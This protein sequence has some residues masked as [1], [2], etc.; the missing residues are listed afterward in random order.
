[1]FDIDRQPLVTT[2]RCHECPASMTI[3]TDSRSQV[4][5]AIADYELRHRCRQTASAA[6]GERRGST[7]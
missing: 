3:E 2:I 6:E 4:D 1:M 7:L 5:Q